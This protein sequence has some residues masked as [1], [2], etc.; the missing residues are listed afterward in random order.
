MSATDAA[1]LSKSARKRANKKAREAEEEPEAPAAPAPAPKATPKA[2]PKAKAKAEAKAA[3]AKAAATPEPKAKAK[4][5]AKAEEPVAAPKPEA[6]AKAKSKAAP[7]EAEPKAKAKA[8]PKKEEQPKAKAKAASAKP[9]AKAGA[10]A[11]AKPE[12]EPEQPKEEADTWI[13]FDDGKGG[14]WEVSTGVSKKQ[15]KRKERVEQEKKDLELLKAAGH[16]KASNQHIPGMAPP[17]VILAQQRAD[18]SNLA[19]NAIAEARAAGAAVRNAAAAGQQAA[20]AES[21]KEAAM[22]TATVK[23]PEAKIG[24]VIGPKGANINLIKEKTGVKNIETNGEICTIVGAENAV[25]LAEAAIR[26]MI[27]KGYM[28]LAFEDFQESGVQVHPSVFPT[29]IG[30]KGVVIQKIKSEAKVEIDIPQG[31]PKDAITKSKKYKVSIAGANAG[32]EKAKEIINAIAMYSCHEVTHPGLTYRE[33]EIE[34]WRYRFL[35]GKNG[36]EMRHIQNNYKVKVNIPREFSAN[37]KVVIVGEAKDIDRACKHIDKVMY[38]ADQPKGRG[39]EDKADDGWGEEDA[40]EDW[41]TP[42]LYKRK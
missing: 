18:A 29:L 11:K 32:V 21:A 27:E 37:D 23:V 35:I 8:E 3:T 7:V 9:T 42:Y 25:A 24:R 5:K 4:A 34:E 2:E 33:L 38:E 26:Q 36:S 19:K 20:A 13:Q 22:S 6:K 12:P 41:M 1:T 10:K 17:E 30:D 15:Q 16:A 39:S 31:I 28:S 40:V 14:D